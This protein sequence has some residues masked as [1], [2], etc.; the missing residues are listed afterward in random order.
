[1]DRL[2][3]EAQTLAHSGK[4]LH[5][6]GMYP[7]VNVQSGDA[8]EFEIVQRIR[9]GD[10]DAFRTLYLTYHRSLWE[11]AHGFLRS[12]QDAE[13]LVQDVFLAVWTTR[14]QWQV[15]DG[16]RAYLYGAV[17]NRALNMLRH[18][19]VVR[20]GEVEQLGSGLGLAMGED[21]QQPDAAAELRELEAAVVRAVAALPERRRVA[22]TLRWRHGLSYPEI[23]KVLGTSPEA[24]MVA[25]S[26]AREALRPI[27]ERH[28]V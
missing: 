14:A 19:R 26:R 10:A 15:R 16:V 22:F 4:S 13:E 3:R 5:V 20:A 9:A 17:R 8:S 27:L 23:G 7:A 24:V 18:A 2:L 6:R 21:P 12:S 25:V 11:F 1:V 28:R